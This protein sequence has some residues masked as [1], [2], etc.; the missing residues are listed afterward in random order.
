MKT[1]PQRNRS[2]G[3]SNPKKKAA[4]STLRGIEKEMGLIWCP[5]FRNTNI[6]RIA[7]CTFRAKDAA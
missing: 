2:E 3:V 6:K 1:P 7:E 5:H 4:N